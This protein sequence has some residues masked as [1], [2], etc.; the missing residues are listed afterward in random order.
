[1]LALSEHLQVGD[2]Y[3]LL[4]MDLGVVCNTNFVLGILLFIFL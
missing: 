1:M 4:T 3:L 2:L